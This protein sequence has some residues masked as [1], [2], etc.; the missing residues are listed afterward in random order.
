MNN[1]QNLLTS[2]HSFFERVKEDTRIIR[3]GATTNMLRHH[4]G[5]H[6]RAI[7]LEMEKPAHYAR[8][9][10]YCGVC[11]TLYVGEDPAL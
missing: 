1:A 11:N 10:C 5:E 9:A 4:C 2:Y 7:A 3:V 8:P 6:K